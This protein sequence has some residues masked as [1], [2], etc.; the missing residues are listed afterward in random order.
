MLKRI[1]KLKAK[2]HF[3]DIIYFNKLNKIYGATKIFQLK[4]SSVSSKV[5]IIGTC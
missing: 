4:V 3:N 2:Y 1:L 5:C